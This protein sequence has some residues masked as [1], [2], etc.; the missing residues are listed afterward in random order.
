MGDDL[1]GRIRFM[2]AQPVNLDGF[3]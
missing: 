1:V 3:A 2:D